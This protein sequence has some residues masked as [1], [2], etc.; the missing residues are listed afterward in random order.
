MKAYLAFVPEGTNG[1][2]GGSVSEVAGNEVSY[3]C[4]DSHVIVIK[5]D[6]CEPSFFVQLVAAGVPSGDA[7][8][9]SCGPF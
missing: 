1:A 9:D 8:D 2:G 5:N 7:N 3:D 4:Y 6:T